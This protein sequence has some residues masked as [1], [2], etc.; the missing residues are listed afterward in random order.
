MDGVAFLQMADQ[1]GWDG[2]H[3]CPKRIHGHLE[4]LQIGVVCQDNKV[5]VAAKFRSSVKHARLS[6][7]QEAL[8]MVRSHRRKGFE[9]RVLVQSFL[10]GE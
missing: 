4:A 2:N 9:C 5:G 8:H 7:H 6:H 1:K 10:L 3:F